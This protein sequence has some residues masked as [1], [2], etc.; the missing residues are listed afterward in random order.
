MATIA[1]VEKIEGLRNKGNGKRNFIQR[2]GEEVEVEVTVVTV[3]I[4]TDNRQDDALDVTNLLSGYMN[5]DDF[6]WVGTVFVVTKDTQTS[7]GSRSVKP[8]I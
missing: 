3:Q 1:R 5:Q 4:T 2:V 7:I 8:K 6:V